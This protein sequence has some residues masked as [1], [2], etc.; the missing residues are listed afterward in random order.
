MLTFFAVVVVCALDAAGGSKPVRIMYHIH[1]CPS[2]K[3]LRAAGVRFSVPRVANSI[4][5]ALQLPYTS[6]DDVYTRGA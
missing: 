4:A 3:M 1:A 5:Q 2:V 6:E